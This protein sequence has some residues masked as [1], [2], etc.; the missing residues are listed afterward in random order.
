MIPVQLTIK[1][2]Y[3]YQQEQTIDFEPLISG[4]LFGIFGSV[5]SGKSSILEAISFA[6]YG[7]TDRLSKQDLR[8]YNMMNLKSDELLIDFT[9]DNHDQQRYRFTVRG[10]RHGKDFGQVGT[11]K[12]AAYK[13]VNHI[14][15]PI[16]SVNAES[17]IGLSY[18]NFHRTIIIPQGKFQEFLQ[19]G[20]AARTEMLKEIFQLDRF[21]FYHQTSALEKSNTEKVN[22]LQGQLLQFEQ[23]NPQIIQEKETSLLHLNAEWAKLNLEHEEAEKKNTALN[24]LKKLLDQLSIFQKQMEELQLRE[25]YFNERE[26]QIKKYE[27]CLREFKNDL[28]N[29]DA[30]QIES[31]KL[32]KSLESTEKDFIQSINQ[33]QE[34]ETQMQE[35]RPQIDQEESQNKQV[36]EINTLLLIRK[37]T[38]KMQSEKQREEKGKEYLEKAREDL[39][40]RVSMLDI[41]KSEI[42]KLNEDLPDT[43]LLLKVK[44]WFNTQKSIENGIIELQ[45]DSENRSTQKLLIQKE[46]ESLTANPDI[47]N[48][49]VFSGW[50]SFVAA[51]P[52]S[53]ATLKQR[54]ESIVHSL[55][56]CQLQIKLGEYTS[57]LKAGKPCPLCGSEHHP[58]ILIVESVEEQMNSLK[59]EKV[60]LEQQEQ[61]L[62][63]TEKHISKIQMNL[64]NIQ[65]EAQL[66]ESKI[67]IKKQEKVEHQNLFVWKND[68]KDEAALENE[69]VRANE[70]KN[71]IKL[72]QSALENAE[73]GMIKLQKD[74]EKYQEGL[75]VIQQTLSAVSGEIST[76]KKQINSI[77]IPDFNE[78]SDEQIER[79]NQQTVA[80]LKQNRNSYEKIQSEIQQKKIDLATLSAR[81]ISI[82]MQQEEKQD[83]FRKY[84]ELLEEKLQQSEFD[85]WEQVMQILQ[86]PL[87]LDKLRD[88]LQQFRQSLFAARERFIHQQNLASGKTLD[89]DELL[90]SNAELESSK[91][92][93]QVL[94]D[95]IVKEKAA[96]ETMSAQLLEKSELE[97]QLAVLELRA[98]DLKLLRQMFIGSGFVSYIS[99]VYLQNLCHVANE[100]FYRLTRQQL[101]LEVN[102]KNEFQVR[103]YL[104]NGHL[105]SV[106]T[107]SGGQT[108]QASL[109]LALALAES[110]QQ[111]SKA[112]Q[113]FFFLDEGFGSLDKDSLQLAFE[114]LKSLRKENRIAGIISHVEDLQQ[115][116]DVFLSVKNDPVQGSII[117]GNWEG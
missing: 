26:I 109:S 81:R 31:E 93:K 94:N 111:Q 64:Q 14:W 104:H 116:I 10:K 39:K 20:H 3:S 105:R 85:Q 6:L 103:D 56:H 49:L 48:L 25:P 92:K 114:T 57:D 27:F 89:Q 37:A 2:L 47:Q 95:T 101:R 44:D 32:Q 70:A 12:R 97:K 79:K 86:N 58:E 77:H 108:F 7:E 113:N 50:E 61:L 1:G 22:I 11:F 9:F 65:N 30:L 51:V 96:F 35:L 74:Q 33:L 107:L 59:T 83:T 13:L 28:Q 102:E 24:E 17:I 68:L 34:L 69:F 46:I 53:R 63:Q 72:K 43:E 29:K 100:R 82:K 19:L 75:Q 62:E 4:Q 78:F 71:L 112:S 18:Q 38:A 41:L 76:L 5:G 23:I 91:S 115:E 110:V 55:Q 15:E 90:H 52:E 98:A 67:A 36:Q 21:E 40:M 42:K 8:N 106:K 54:N 117:R 99:S 45:K 16:E 84:S 73:A 88:E 66:I 80:K 60:L 87:D